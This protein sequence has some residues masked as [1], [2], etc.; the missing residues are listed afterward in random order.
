MRQALDDPTLAGE[1]RSALLRQWASF[2]LAEAQT[3]ADPRRA[4]EL[5][6]QVIDMGQMPEDRLSWVCERL[7]AVGRYQRVIELIEQRL[8]WGRPLPQDF[9]V[10]LE[11]AYRGANR[12]DDAERAATAAKSGLGSGW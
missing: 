7:N 8:L 11:R 5:C 3:T 6:A 4:A 1:A 12:P 10:E 2:L 9:P